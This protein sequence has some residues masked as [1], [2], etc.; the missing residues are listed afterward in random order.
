M[1]RIL[2]AVWISLFLSAFLFQAPVQ[3]MAQEV[4]TQALKDKMDSEY[5]ELVI[6]A[7][8][9]A[10]DWAMRLDT[11]ND[12]LDSSRD[13]LEELNKQGKA[14]LV[15]LTDL[16]AVVSQEGT[17]VT[18]GN[19][20]NYW[21]MNYGDG[22]L[23]AMEE[24]RDDTFIG[25][26]RLDTKDILKYGPDCGAT[27]TLDQIIQSFA[28]NSKLEVM[29]VASKLQDLYAQ[30]GK[31][32]PYALQSYFNLEA[33]LKGEIGQGKW[34]DYILVKY[35]PVTPEKLKATGFY[36]KQLLMGSN[37]DPSYHYIAKLECPY[38]MMYWIWVS[39]DYDGIKQTLLTWK[40][41]VKW[42]WDHD[43]NA[44]VATAEPG[45]FG[46][47]QEDNK[48]PMT[49]YYKGNDEDFYVDM[50]KYIDEVSGAQAQTPAATPEPTPATLK[51]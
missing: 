25:P 26:W 42:V 1:R 49:G 35:P 6:K 47:T 37:T 36:G 9:M 22:T 4:D 24:T 44:P 18:A 3:V 10:L 50:K 21:G 30:F 15:E 8:K 41:Q 38:G 2:Q 34:D 33:Y 20:L 5:K 17:Y 13:A 23:R 39:R 45:N 11:I 7:R 14:P 48:A 46:I 16:W 12:L 32:S 19:I 27:G 51:E 40:N 31:R 28:D 29:I 43:K